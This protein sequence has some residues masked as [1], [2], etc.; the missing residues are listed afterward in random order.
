MECHNA[1]ANSE[2][3][4]QKID[5]HHNHICRE[6]SNTHKNILDDLL[7]NVSLS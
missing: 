6:L 5:I 2:W 1:T 3:L 7:R 4:D